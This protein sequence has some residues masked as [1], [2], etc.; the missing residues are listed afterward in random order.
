LVPFSVLPREHLVSKH[1]NHQVPAVVLVCLATL[2]L[3]K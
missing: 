1:Q 3:K 2:P